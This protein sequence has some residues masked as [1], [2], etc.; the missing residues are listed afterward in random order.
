MHLAGVKKRGS[1]SKKPLII[2]ALILAVIIL[3]LRIIAHLHQNM[4]TGDATFERDVLRNKATVLVLFYL[5]SP[6]KDSKE[7]RNTLKNFHTEVKSEIFICNITNNFATA[8]KYKATIGPTLAVFDHGSLLGKIVGN[9]DKDGLVR[10]VNKLLS[11][12]HKAPAPAQK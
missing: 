9:K 3:V 8:S 6:D 1:G 5:P 10:Q 11:E 12:Q 7:M 2:A 4:S